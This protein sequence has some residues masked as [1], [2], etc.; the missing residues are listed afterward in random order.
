MLA[1]IASLFAACTMQAQTPTISDIGANAPSPGPNDQ[2][3]LI[4]GSGSPDGLNYYFDNSTPPGQTFTTGGNAGGYILDTV[5]LATAGD[6]GNLPAGGQAYVLRIYQVNNGTDATLVASYTSQGSFTFTDFDWLQWTNLGAQLLPNTQYAYSFGIVT[7]GSGWE[8]MANVSGDPYPGGEVVLIPKTGGTM[9]FGSSHGFDAAFVVGLK[10]AT[11]LQAGTPYFS[12]LSPVTVGTQVTA[13][14]TVVGSGPL[15]YQ[16]RTD[17]GGGGTLTNIP[18][19]TGSSLAVDTTSF[20]T[21]VYRYSLFVTNS[22]SSVTSAPAALVVG[23]VVVPAGA[24]LTDCGTNISSGTSDVSQFVG[25]SG[26]DYDGLNYYDDN[27]SVRNVW[28]G[29]TFTTGTNSQGY[30][31]ASVALQTGGGSSLGTGTPQLY[32]L[33]IYQVSGNEAAVIAHYTNSQ[34]S[35]T[36]GDWLQWKAPGGFML[37]LKPNTTYAYGFGCDDYN[38]GWAGLNS[39]STA[40]DLYQGG[41]TCGIPSGGGNITFSQS[42]IEDAVFDIGL[43]P[44]ASI[45]PYMAPSLTP[46]SGII[47]DSKPTGTPFNGLSSGTTWLAADSDANAVTR[48]GVEHFTATNNSVINQ[49]AYG[50]LASTNG[51]ICFWIRMSTNFPGVGDE[52]AMVM[53]WRSKAPNIGSIIAITRGNYGEPPGVVFVQS[54]GGA[55]N[56]FGNVAVDDGNWHF[57]AVTYGQNALD[58]VEIYVD[59]NLDAATS[60]SAAWA[61]PIGVDNT[62]KLGT[63]RD[64]YWLN[65]DGNLDDFRWYSRVLDGTE[66]QQAMSGAIVDTN[67]LQARF[68]FNATPSAGFT[69]SSTPVTGLVPQV[70]T[71]LPIFND[72]NGAVTPYLIAPSGNQFFRVHTP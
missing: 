12:P 68:N 49:T 28:M 29:Q 33:F 50:P 5:S 54:A 67:T 3:Q 56:F 25:D 41:Q 53:D 10:L 27:G 11:V 42:G 48:N 23:P 34:F 1:V 7:G 47:P 71:N 37:K 2:A 60:A 6:S 9:T 14:S 72:L 26:G 59:G 19:A 15:N 57:V 64:S 63:S 17:G 55:V 13:S 18:G 30:Y 32:H 70:S 31:L 65:L 4:T 69:L 21:G 51:T 20:D 58:T 44:I 46:V 43:L 40:A 8:N 35:Y 45:S 24:I 52:A 38:N 62:I 16:W 39:S 66:V 61:W 22:T 36:Y